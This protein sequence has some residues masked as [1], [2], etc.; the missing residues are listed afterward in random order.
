MSDAEQ[1]IFSF[2]YLA[3]IS[4]VISIILP[5]SLCPL[6]P[7]TVPELEQLALHSQEELSDNGPDAPEFLPALL[8]LQP[9]G[10]TLVSQKQ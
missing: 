9:L 3:V 6:C 7:E 2:T 5:G 10:E 8:P 1:L 4:P